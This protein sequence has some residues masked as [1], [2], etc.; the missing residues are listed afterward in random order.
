[1]RTSKLRCRRE[2][3]TRHSLRQLSPTVKNHRVSKSG[4]E[5]FVPWARGIA[6]DPKR[7][8]DLFCLSHDAYLARVVSVETQ[9]NS[10][11]VNSGFIC[12]PVLGQRSL[13]AVTGRSRSAV[14]YW[15]SGPRSRSTRAT[16]TD[17]CS[18]PGTAY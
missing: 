13:P 4:S 12:T 14:P 18:M 16:L 5:V 1:M 15:L 10:G 2:I 9:A 11:T 7:P 3:G 8:G 6:G 17:G